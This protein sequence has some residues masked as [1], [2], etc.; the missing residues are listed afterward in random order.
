MMSEKANLFGDTVTR[1][2]ISLDPAQQKRLGS[3][4]SNFNQEIW[5]CHRYAIVFKGNL[6]KV[7]PFPLLQQLLDTGDKFLDE[8]SPHDL[9]RLSVLGPMAGEP[10][11][12]S[13]GGDPIF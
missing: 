10:S 3:P 9:V 6:A 2:N 5:E 12:L 7:S 1:R 4:V 11:D 13:S 8:A